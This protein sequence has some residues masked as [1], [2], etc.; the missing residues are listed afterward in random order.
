MPARSRPFAERCRSGESYNIG[1]HAERTNRAVVEAICAMLDERWPRAAG[2]RYRELITFVTD[3]PGH[4][5][6]YAIDPAKAE[7]DLE[8][9]ATETFETGL[10]KTIDWYLSNDWWWR[11]IR[12]G[13]YRGQ[14]LGT[15]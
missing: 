5:L 3:R 8:W 1:G 2:K 12:E 9:R 14:R 15:G 4:D 11:P 13:R 10:A 6:R 7:R